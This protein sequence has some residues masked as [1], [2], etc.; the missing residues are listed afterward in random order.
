MISYL[1]MG[2]LKWGALQFFEKLGEGGSTR[3]GYPML[4]EAMF[5]TN[6]LNPYQS[7]GTNYHHHRHYLITVE[8]QT[9]MGQR[10]KGMVGREG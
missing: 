2:L 3:E 6:L 10:R 8:M 4:F 1:G 9:M 5:C 7:C